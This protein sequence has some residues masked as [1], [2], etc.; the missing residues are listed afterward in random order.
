MHYIFYILDSV[1]RVATTTIM[2]IP[3]SKFQVIIII[4]VFKS[5]LFSQSMNMKIFA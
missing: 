2:Q 4:Y 5:W 3:L 1:S